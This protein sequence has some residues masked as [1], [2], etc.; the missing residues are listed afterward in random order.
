ME[1]LLAGNLA[2][3]GAIQASVLEWA[4]SGG[5]TPGWAAAQQMLAERFPLSTLQARQSI[6]NTARD[7]VAIGAAY[8]RAGDAYAPRLSNLPDVRVAERYAG[9]VPPG[10]LS[11]SAARVVYHQLELRITDPARPGHIVQITSHSEESNDVLSR[12][13]LMQI[14]N[15]LARDYLSQFQ[16]YDPTALSPSGFQVS[17]TIRGA[18]I[19]Y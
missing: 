18:Y 13:Q 10:G 12:S 6:I 1:P 5:G 3:A 8:Q 16:S 11:G 9:I 17:V 4:R 2:F 15:D 7:Q 19:G 14:G